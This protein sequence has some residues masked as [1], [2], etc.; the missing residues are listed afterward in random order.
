MWLHTHAVCTHDDVVTVSDESV[1]SDVHVFGRVVCVS[2]YVY[3]LLALAVTN[4]HVVMSTDFQICI[5]QH[6]AH[7]CMQTQT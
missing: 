1:A 6:T 7:T 2:V 5:Y 4:V 3:M